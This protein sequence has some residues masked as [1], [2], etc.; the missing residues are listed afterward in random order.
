VTD[1]PAPKPD[2][3]I[4]NYETLSVEEIVDRLAP[5]SFTDL[6][7]IEEHE[8][9][10]ESRPAVLSRISILRGGQPS[11]REELRITAAKSA[12]PHDQERPA[13]LRSYRD[14]GETR[15]NILAA[16]EKELTGA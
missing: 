2:L 5:L 15:E 9:D 16:A 8:R 12:P 6:A 11:V 3:P 4:A 14:M 7:K 10:H 13:P 1:V